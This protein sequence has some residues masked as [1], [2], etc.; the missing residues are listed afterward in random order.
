MTRTDVSVLLTTLLLSIWLWYL[1]E[2]YQAWGWKPSRQ[3]LLRLLRFRTPHDCP[4]CG[5]EH[6]GR[7]ERSDVL[8]AGGKQAAAAC[9]VT[10][11]EPTRA[12][13]AN[14][15]RRVCLSQQ[16][17]RLL[18]HSQPQDPCVDRLWPAGQVRTDS[19]PILPGVRNQGHEAVG[20]TDVQTQDDQ[21]AGSNGP[22]SFGRGT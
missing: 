15:D 1:Y 7:C 17:V 9:L 8:V 22:H 4:C 10:S 21:Q 20:D 12:Q 5:E 16:G 3:K 19:E 11:E 13:E 18:R 6:L 2:L 14:Q